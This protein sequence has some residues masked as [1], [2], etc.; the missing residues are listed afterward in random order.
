METAL[1]ILQKAGVALAGLALNP[2]YYAALLFTAV[3]FRRQVAL[4]RKQF[5][6]RL[7]APAGLFLHALIWGWI[8]GLAISVLAMAA[9]LVLQATTMLWV[10]GTAVVLLLFRIRYLNTVYAAGA[11]ILLHEAAS[12]IAALQDIPV[13]GAW[14]A[15]LEAVHPPSLL[16]LVALLCAAEALLLL[17]H[18]E[19][20]A[21][22]VYVAGKRGKGIGAFQ[23]QAF[24]AL[25]LF[26]VV[27]AAAGSGMAEWWPWPHFFGGD[28]A[29][30]AGWTLLAFPAMLGFTGMIASA[31]PQL[32][33]KR[34]AMELL[35]AGILLLVLAAAAELWPAAAPVAA[36]GAVVAL[37]LHEGIV[38]RHD[39]LERRSIPF[40]VHEGKGLKILAVVPGG[41]ASEMGIA[42][43][44]TIL[45][46]NG[47]PVSSGGQ[48]H[49]ALRAN[50][51]FCRLEVA[52]LNG[53]SK[54]VQRALFAGEHHQLGIVLC[55]DDRISQ[56]TRWR[57]LTL[58]ALLA[59]GSGA[60]RGLEP[61]A[62]GSG[63]ERGDESGEDRIDGSD[64]VSEKRDAP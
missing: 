6:L 15:T 11:V 22:P 40:F 23:V 59:P 33:I 4:Q 50:P 2:F 28:A 39:R 19:R 36:F 31:P 43:G 30:E 5:H 24:W 46:V 64:Q 57:P 20:M 42:A 60:G 47:R 32:R 62:A 27:P 10:W 13:A 56:Q 52:D 58:W 54:F 35:A 55:P 17:L 3:V 53:E 29:W 61:P 37:L 26:L 9:G 25:P 18:G 44:E 7:H 49:A 48:L 12:R 34:Y 16:A 8:C 63:E 38:L 45:K 14:L 21:S 1:N 41:P 51:A